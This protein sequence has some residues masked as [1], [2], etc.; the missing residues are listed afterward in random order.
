[1][2]PVP[3]KVIFLIWREIHVFSH[4]STECLAGDYQSLSFETVHREPG[5]GLEG[6]LVGSDG[7]D[8]HKHTVCVLDLVSFQEK[9]GQFPDLGFLRFAN[10]HGPGW[11]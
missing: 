11:N 9:T 5:N 7:F 3:P 4:R 8:V 1:M 2:P 6:G 10:S